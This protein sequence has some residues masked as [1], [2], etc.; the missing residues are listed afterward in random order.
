MGMGR[1]SGEADQRKEE[2][3]R[4]GGNRASKS[5]QDVYVH[6]PVPKDRCNYYASQTY[7]NKYLKRP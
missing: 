2:E 1:E 4:L 6:V 3:G 7:T 5:D